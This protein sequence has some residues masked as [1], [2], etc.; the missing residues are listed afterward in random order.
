MSKYEADIEE[1]KAEMKANAT[2]AI[3]A[4]PAAF[5]E[6]NLTLNFM[7]V[8]GNAQLDKHRTF[9]QYRS[10]R[11]E[12]L[13]IVFF[14]CS[15]SSRTRASRR[16]LLRSSSRPRS[17]MNFSFSGT[18]PN[19]KQA[20]HLFQ[21]EVLSPTLRTLLFALAPQ[22]TPGSGGHGGAQGHGGFGPSGGGAPRG[23]GGR[24][25]EESGS[26]EVGLAVQ[27]F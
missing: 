24:R 12:T 3:A 15:P 10:E 16:P 11:I 26:A 25:G 20:R 5:N 13:R 9:K 23:R 21:V 14:S 7:D 6:V 18:S 27:D 17:A 4:L 19:T 1:K 22:G 8:A 2:E